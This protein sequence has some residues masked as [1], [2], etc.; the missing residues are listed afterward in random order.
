ME[1]YAKSEP[2]EN[3]ETLLQHT[4]TLLKEF[5]SFKQLYRDRILSLLPEKYREMFWQLLELVI[6]YHDLGKIHTPFQTRIRASINFKRKKYNLPLLSDI[7][8]SDIEE[9]PHNLLSPAFLKDVVKQYPEEIRPVVYQVV[10]Y[11]HDNEREEYFVV[12]RD[13]WE[14]IVNVIE[15]DIN[16]N[17]SRLANLQNELKIS[18]PQ[19]LSGVYKIFPRIS[20]SDN[21]LYGLYLFLKGLLHRIDHSASAHLDI[22]RNPI[23]QSE[24]KITSHFTSKNILNIWQ[25][26]E[27]INLADKNVI[28]VASTGIGKTEYALYW[29]GDNKGFYVLPMRT[30]V[31]AM[32]ERIQ[33]IFSKEKENIGLLHSDAYFYPLER[34]EAKELDIADSNSESFSVSLAQ[35]YAARQLSMPLTISTADQL[36]P[37][38]FKYGGYEKIYATLGYSKVIIDEIQSYDPQIAAIILQGLKEISEIGGHFCVV[39][40]T[41][42]PF[43]KEYLLKE[44]PNIIVP[45]PQILNVAKHKVKML[46]VEKL[47]DCIPEFVREYDRYKRVLVVVNTVKRAQELYDLIIK[48]KK[49]PV[50]LLHAAFTYEDRRQREKMLLS[51]NPPEGIWIAT[52]LVEV[53][54]NID[55]PVIFTEIASL[56]VLI[57]RMGRI[58]RD[59]KT[60]GFKYN[61]KPNVW[62][63]PEHLSSGIGYIYDS[64][65]VSTTK[66]IITSHDGLLWSEHFKQEMMGILFSKKNTRYLDKFKK[67]LDILES[68]MTSCVTRKDAHDLFR[69]MANITVLPTEVYQKNSNSIDIALEK[70][71]KPKNKEEKI[72]ALYTLKKYSISVPYYKVK[73][74]LSSYGQNIFLTDLKYSDKKGL[75]PNKLLESIL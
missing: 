7:P 30:S 55:F 8:H 73:N 20:K 61:G 1:I 60:E 50:Y 44:I 39:T 51:K 9:V 66:E 62:V 34:K 18:I 59:I 33:E 58:L 28:L 14:K 4:K 42:S 6:L 23:S 56:D 5:D 2:I 27:A 19:D 72:S 74:N 49:I 35:F 26:P 63:I 48:E 36:F 46:D 64:T 11:H 70:I 21:S 17:V 75:I 67:S 53:S 40:A 38:V 13:N 3:P 29:L 37:A 41:L 57:Q 12:D 31:T 45:S 24:G 52:Q 54:L 71:K 15:K 43:Y 65:L 22:E 69:P 47:Q 16:P 32:Y 10:A 68:G 25:K